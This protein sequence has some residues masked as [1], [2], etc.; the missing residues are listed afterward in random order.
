MAIKQDKVLVG[1]QVLVHTYSDKRKKIKCGN[2]VYDDAY[3]VAAYNYTETDEDVSA[4]FAETLK[5]SEL[6]EL[7]KEIEKLKA[8]QATQN[9]AIEAG[10]DGLTDLIATVMGGDS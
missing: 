9:E 2:Y 8:E 7:R 4:E 6:A 1:G 10:A 3:D 5:G